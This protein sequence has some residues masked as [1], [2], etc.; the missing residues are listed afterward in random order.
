MKNRYQ[1]LKKYWVPLGAEQDA[2]DSEEEEMQVPPPQTEPPAEPQLAVR[3]DVPGAAI[4][5][6][7][8]QPQ[9]MPE[10]YEV[11][12]ANGWQ[13]NNLPP[14]MSQQQDPKGLYAC[15]REGATTA[16]GPL[17]HKFLVLQSRLHKASQLIARENH[18]EQVTGWDLEFSVSSARTA[19]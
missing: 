7:Q 4:N 12:G 8:Q 13:I 9:V 1:A 6:T 17:S 2:I 14:G 3:A 5:S 10:G 19:L 11:E 16:D 18:D 15:L